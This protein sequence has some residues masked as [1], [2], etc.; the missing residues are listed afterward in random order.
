MERSEDLSRLQRDWKPPVE[1]ERAGPREVKLAGAGIAIA[2]LACLLFAGA[3]AAAVGLTGVSRRSA[4]EV[5]ALDESAT[6]I[7]AVVT[8]HWKTSG[9]SSERRITYQFEYAGRTYHGTSR[10]PRD[11]WAR[12]DVGSPIRVR[13]VA[14]NPE[15]SHPAGWKKD[16][17]PSWLPPVVALGLILPGMLMLYA[18]RRQVQLL[19][20]GRPAPAIV[21]GHRRVKGGRI[22]RYEFP[23]L[24]GR[25]GK[26]SGGHSRR[27]APVGSTITVV[28]DRDNPKRNAPYPFEMVRI[29][30]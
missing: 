2:C 10:A 18:I 22:L 1:L 3:I 21:T 26:G 20:D 17:L 16:V 15:L 29:V 8:R 6:E 4:R 25:V 5:A 30:R 12:I 27:P 19:S 24:N 28:Y 7:Q 14:G 9:E 13:F 11:I 23:L